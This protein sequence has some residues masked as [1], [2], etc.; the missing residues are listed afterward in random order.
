MKGIIMLHDTSAHVVHTV[1]DTL[2]SM[3]FKVSDY[4][5]C[6]PDFSLWEFHVSSHLKKVLKGHKVRSDEDIKATMVQ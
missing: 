3:R 2:H 4:L 1:Q 6:S 5:P